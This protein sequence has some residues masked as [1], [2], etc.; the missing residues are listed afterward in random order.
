MNESAKGYS[1]D[2]AL[3]AFSGFFFLLVNQTEGFLNPFSIAGDVHNM[4]LV[5]AVC[6]MTASS[7]SLTQILVYPSEKISRVTGII[8]GVC[9]G[10]FF[11]VTFC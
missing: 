1:S 7:I 10:F 5:F 8:V 9:F 2:F 11:M 3:V 6:A 4:D